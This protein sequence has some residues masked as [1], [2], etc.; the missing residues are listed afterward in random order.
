MMQLHSNTSSAMNQLGSVQVNS[1]TPLGVIRDKLRGLEV[2]PTSTAGYRVKQKARIQAVH[3]LNRLDT[4]DH[5]DEL[6]PAF[7][8][9]LRCPE[10]RYQYCAAERTRCALDELGRWCPPEDSAEAEQLLRLSTAPRLHWRCRIAPVVKC[11]FVSF[12]FV[13][14][15]TALYLTLR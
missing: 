11:V 6:W 10:N 1:I 2:P 14:S 9:W 5:L 3:W 15:L 4:T 7:E 8:D 12:S 13:A